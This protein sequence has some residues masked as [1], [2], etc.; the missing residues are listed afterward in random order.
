MNCKRPIVRTKTCCDHSLCRRR[1][2]LRHGGLCPDRPLPACTALPFPFS[3]AQDKSQAGHAIRKR[4]VA[5]DRTEGH[6]GRAG[7]V[8]V[9][10]AIP[11]PRLRRGG[12][13]SGT[14][15]AIRATS[16]RRPD[17]TRVVAGVPWSGKSLR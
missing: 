2:G 1:G 4:T 16:K 6:V 3:T 11:F 8:H 5:P 17:L 7:D 12:Q 14:M 9:L 15:I 13:D 10:A